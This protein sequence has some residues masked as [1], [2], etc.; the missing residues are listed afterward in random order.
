MNIKNRA[1]PH[2]GEAEPRVTL[3]Q[4]PR[5]KQIDQKTERQL[6][7][8]LTKKGCGLVIDYLKGLHAQDLEFPS[9]HRL[10]DGLAEAFNKLFVAG[11]KWIEKIRE[12]FGLTQFEF[13]FIGNRAG[14]ITL[15]V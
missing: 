7:R 4:L 6:R 11:K 8:E 10:S 9:F 13:D 1:F 3:V 12:A 2:M 5:V 14:Q 15:A